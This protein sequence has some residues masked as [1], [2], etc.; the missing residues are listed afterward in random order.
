MGAPDGATSALTALRPLAAA[1]AC[2]VELLTSCAQ[3]SVVRFDG[4]AVLSVRGSSVRRGVRG[5]VRRTLILRRPRSSSLFMSSRWS[6]R[7]SRSR[8]SSRTHTP[9]QTELVRHARGLRQAVLCSKRK[10]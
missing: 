10:R 8:R 3:T 1:V 5:G 9:P 7:R 2:I 4:W 6:L